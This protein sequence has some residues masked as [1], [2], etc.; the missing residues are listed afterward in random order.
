M[1]GWKKIES[2]K[3]FHEDFCNYYY[4]YFKFS[5]DFA[6]EVGNVNS[7]VIACV[8]INHDLKLIKRTNGYW[9][10][11]YNGVEHCFLPSFEKLQKWINHY[12]FVR[13][14]NEISSSPPVIKKVT[15]LLPVDKTDLDIDK[16][17]FE[18][19]DNQFELKYGYK[20]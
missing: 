11:E 9:C 6:E 3:I 1:S 7:D 20:P 14:F 5:L 4:S 2:A 19:W 8:V 18:Y 16:T 12:I 17:V 15:N 10:S 13:K